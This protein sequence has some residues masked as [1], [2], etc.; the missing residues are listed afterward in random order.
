[1]ESARRGHG[2]A[3]EGVKRVQPIF[4]KNQEDLVIS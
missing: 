2:G 4:W 1:M 3:G